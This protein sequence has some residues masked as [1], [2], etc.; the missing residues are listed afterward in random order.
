M[1]KIKTPG[2]LWV[3]VAG[4]LSAFGA[5]DENGVEPLVWTTF[6]AQDMTNQGSCSRVTW[7]DSDIRFEATSGGYAGYVGD[8]G[9]YPFY[10]NSGNNI[11]WGASES[12]TFAGVFKAGDAGESY[13]CLFG[14][15][16]CD[17]HVIVGVTAH[18]VKLAWRGNG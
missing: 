4:A 10:K 12:C 16:W 14:M 11:E 15:G 3:L 8:S 2:C 5:V 6:D 18:S 13:A 9:K 1:Q 7:G 17:T